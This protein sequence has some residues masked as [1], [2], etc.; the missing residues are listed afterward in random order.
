MS[1]P[2]Q[3]LGNVSEPASQLHSSTKVADQFPIPLTSCGTATI[4][5]MHKRV[6]QGQFATLS[7]DFW[8]LPSTLLS[9]TSKPLY[10]M[11]LPKLVH[12]KNT[13]PHS[14]SLTMPQFPDSFDLDMAEVAAAAA[15][16]AEC[17]ILL[18]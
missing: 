12:A 6:Q 13:M 10:A 14:S 1:A 3:I 18:A 4:K 2:G 5:A 16:A 11:D 8:Q 9:S 7:H 15:A 17:L